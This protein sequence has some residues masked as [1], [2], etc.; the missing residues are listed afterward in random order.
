M[1]LAKAD[2]GSII[3]STK[4][5]YQWQLSSSFPSF[6]WF[7]VLAVSSPVWRSSS[8][9]TLLQDQNKVAVVNM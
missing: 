6:F 7:F 8:K 4:P 9:N 5:F 3:N 1:Q 2:E